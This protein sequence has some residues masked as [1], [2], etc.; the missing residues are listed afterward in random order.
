MKGEV[1]SPVEQLIGGD[2]F[3]STRY[4]I[5]IKTENHTTGTSK[6]N[7][8]T[9]DLISNHDLRNQTDVIDVKDQNAR[10][11]SSFQKFGRILGHRYR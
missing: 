2:A 5:M 10:I 4:F 7:T 3:D 6:H 11:R 1:V 8:S 9:R